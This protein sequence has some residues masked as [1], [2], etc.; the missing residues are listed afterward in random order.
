MPLTPPTTGLTRDGEVGS[1]AGTAQPNPIDSKPSPHRPSAEA[2]TAR[3]AL[4]AMRQ[5]ALPHHALVCL[6]KP[7]ALLHCALAKPPSPEIDLD[8]GLGA[9]IGAS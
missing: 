5:A 7:I 1:S 4:G 8:D 6:R 3:L 2:V 9:P